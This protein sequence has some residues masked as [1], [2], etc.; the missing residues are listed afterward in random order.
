M[1][2]LEPVELLSRQARKCDH[3]GLGT[4]KVRQPRVHDRRQVQSEK[5]IPRKILPPL[6]ADDQEY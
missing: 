5:P 2:I 1:L 3:H 4:V 6:L